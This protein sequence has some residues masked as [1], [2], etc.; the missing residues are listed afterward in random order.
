M[1]SQG[2]ASGCLHRVR[3]TMM[4]AQYLSVA[5]ASARSENLLFMLWNMLHTR[6]S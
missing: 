1:C 2:D 5:D 4:R 3:S 6:R